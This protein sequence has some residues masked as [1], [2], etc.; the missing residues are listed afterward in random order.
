[1]K[2][3][4]LLNNT[5]PS[6]PPPPLIS[7]EQLAISNVIK[8]SIVP[9]ELAHIFHWFVWFV[10]VRGKILTFQLPRYPSNN[11]LGARAPCQI[12]KHLV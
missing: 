1:M 4:T 10:L 5:N 7:N 9:H 12:E 2:N 11:R 6:P 8:L 3:L